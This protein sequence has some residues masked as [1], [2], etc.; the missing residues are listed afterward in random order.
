MKRRTVN[1]ILCAALV[2]S[3]AMPGFASEETEAFDAQE[4]VFAAQIQESEDPVIIA[5][6]ITEIPEEEDFSAEELIDAEEEMSSGSDG[7]LDEDTDN[8]ILTAAG[9]ELRIEY[10]PN[11][12]DGSL[13]YIEDSSVTLTAKITSGGGSGAT[14]FWVYDEMKQP[15][16]DEAYTPVKTE[17]GVFTSSLEV[18]KSGYYTIKTITAETSEEIA[19]HVTFMSA[20][21]AA[22]PV[23]S[24]RYIVR[25]GAEQELKVKMFVTCE[26]P[27]VTKRWEKID[28]KTGKVLATY[29]GTWEKD[30]EYDS[31]YYSS[32]KTGQVGDYVFHIDDGTNRYRVSFA[33]DVDNRIDAVGTNIDDWAKEVIVSKGGGATLTC[34]VS[35]K[36]KYFDHFTYSWR[37][38]THKTNIAGTGKSITLSNI[39]SSRYVTVSGH[40][41]D[42]FGNETEYEYWF[43]IKVQN[44]PSKKKATGKFNKSSVTIKKGKT[45]KKLKVTKMKKGDYVAKV[46]SSKKSVVEVKSFT[47]KGKIVL[48]AKKKGTAKITA[49]LASGKKIKIKIKVKK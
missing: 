6:E 16:L 28:R 7:F 33:V 42:R 5:D 44:P 19:F 46:T 34:P 11:P 45:Y 41:Y 36:G 37:D 4:A 47:A 20:I 49:T 23:G 25:P 38:E 29:D 14:M 17:K 10:S 1:F 24:T 3:T 43:H 40:I 13:D 18:T 31:F 35:Y 8:E 32:I 21:A 30:Q 27:Q 12:Y 26:N 9:E 39:T 22:D 48:K 2:I 15:N